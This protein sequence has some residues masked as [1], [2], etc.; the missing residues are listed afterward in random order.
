MKREDDPI[1]AEAVRWHLASGD[2][3][4][5]WDAFTLWLEADPAHRKAFDEIALTDMMLGEHRE[6]LAE[7]AAP[8][9]E[10]PMEATYAEAA[11]DRVVRPVFGKRLRWAGFA[12]AAALTAV[13]AVPQ[14]MGPAPELYETAA[15]SQRIAL[16]DGSTILLAPRS[17]L[18]IEGRNRDRMALSGGALFDIRHDPS[19]R[20]TITAGDLAISDIGTR[21]DVQEQKD[22]VRVAVV[23][24]KVQVSSQALDA[25]VKLAAGSGLDFDGAKGTATIASI[26]PVDVGSWQEGRL[27]YENARLVLVAADLHRYAGVSVEVPASLRDRRFSGTLIVDDGDAALR[28]LV[29][30]MGL[31]LSGHAGAWRLEQP[32]S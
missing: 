14:F 32:G 2:D 26:K 31:R 4:M 6:E 8:E 9:F 27:S 5:D 3:S 16:E 10:T 1:L 11:N 17:H 13:L 25:P 7:P 20:L 18:T 21:F 12:V 24:G 29:Q 23:E 19:R 30:L 22:T 15:A 28:D